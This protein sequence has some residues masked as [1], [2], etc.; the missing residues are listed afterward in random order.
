MD[1]T[2]QGGHAPAT[3]E[4]LEGLND[5]LQLDHD[6][7]GAYGIAMEK[8]EDRDAAAQIAGYLRDHERHVR[9]LNELIRE[10]GGTPTNEPHAT[11]PFKEALQS[12]GA[13]AGDKG[14]LMAWRANEMQVRTKYDAYASKA[15]L[16]PHEAK[17]VIDRNALDE[18]RH[19]AWVAGV[20]D[21]MGG[22]GS[23][24]LAAARE[25]VGDAL[26]AVGGKVSAGASAVANRLS[27]MFDPEG[28]GR[29][30][31]VGARVSDAGD[32]AGELVER[33]ED[34]VR[35]SPLQTLLVAAVAGFVIGR[36]LR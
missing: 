1:T 17:R 13:L 10:L 9:D 22:H 5:L 32:R 8:L 20:L 36:L 26:G 19:Y 15:M 12:I 2:R 25:K 3:S 11:G 29:L 7:I 35:E 28:D 6:A 34:Q 18:E 14:I 27:G 33:F 21:A 23:D 24:A 16:W 30:A 31:P 4:V